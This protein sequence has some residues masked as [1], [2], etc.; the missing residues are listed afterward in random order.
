MARGTVNTTRGRSGILSPTL[1]AV[2][3]NGSILISVI[4][5][6]QLQLS[7]S[8]KWLEDL[9]GMTILAKIVEANND[10]TGTIP[11]TAHASPAITNLTIIDDTLTDS[12]FKIV[13]PETLIAS[14]NHA[15]L[16]EKPVYGFIGLEVADTGIGTAQ[17]IWKPLRGLVEVKYSPT[18]V[19]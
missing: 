19:S 8:L 17:Q 3:D 15:P 16:P 6:E 7:I 11:S 18:E 12:E 10:G 4:H 2:T 1:D 9:T 5:G 13:I 14:W